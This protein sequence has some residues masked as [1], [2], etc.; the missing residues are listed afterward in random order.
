M[1][2]DINSTYD[3]EAPSTILDKSDWFINNFKW[4]TFSNT[5]SGYTLFM[6]STSYSDNDDGDKDSD[7]FSANYQEHFFHS[8]KHGVLKKTSPLISQSA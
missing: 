6:F 5:N 8:P 1:F 7:V 3:L 2:S 4:K